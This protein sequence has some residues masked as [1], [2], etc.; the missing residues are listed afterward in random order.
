MN[1]NE[2]TI[3]PG[4]LHP[5]LAA[6]LASPQRTGHAL[7]IHGQ[8]GVG[9]RLLARA[10][11]R[12]L[13]CE[14]PDAALRAGG[15][16]NVCAACGWFEQGNHPDFRKIVPEALAVAEG[17]E[18]TDDAG[19]GEGAETLDAG[20]RSKRAP[21][22]E[23]KVDQVRALQ[24]FLSVA[25]HRSGGRVVLLYPVETLNDVA[26]N[27]LLKM[28][29]E[30]PARTVFV[31]VADHL[32]RLPATIVSRCRKA[33]VPTPAPAVAVAWLAGQG[34]ADPEAALSAAGGAPLN[35]LAFAGDAA[36]AASRQELLAFLERPA[37]DA[38]LAAAEAFGRA[39]AAPLIRWLQQ[40]LADCIAM[41][42]AERIRYHPA[43]SRTIATLSR[44]ASLDAL[45]QL[46][47]RLDAIRR[48]IDHPLN[49][50][51]LL[52]H[53]LTAYADAMGPGQGRPLTVLTVL[54]VL[55]LP[56]LPPDPIRDE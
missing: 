18:T 42:L 22:K 41:R 13:L 47:Q 10:I 36:A 23:I 19:E 37:V 8:E 30:P 6:T 2:L 27:A 31:L 4:W 38:A 51:L 49:T 46:M 20:P 55:T 9:K 39:P 11:A 1:P 12:G 5:I 50:R 21:S 16:C 53:V 54:T 56:T 33:F 3:L 29:E 28:L 25:T 40:W 45:L 15:G 17:L 48:T 32:G 52:E 24:A 7:L 34:V 26:A 35:A 43:Q 14:S 44:S